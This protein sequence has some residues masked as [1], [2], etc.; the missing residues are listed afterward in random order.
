M[1]IVTY[2][3]HS[4]KIRSKFSRLLKKF[5]RMLQYS[6]Y[7]I[8]NSERILRILKTEIEFTFMPKFI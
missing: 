7:E 1:L 2:D 6:V 5:G 4:D 8:K 3:I